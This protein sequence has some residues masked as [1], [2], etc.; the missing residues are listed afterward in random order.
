MSEK[1]TIAADVVT[2]ADTIGKVLAGH[3]PEW[4]SA[5]LADLTARWLAGCHPAMREE[6]FRVHNELVLK[7]TAVNEFLHFGPD[8]HPGWKDLEKPQ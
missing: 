5:V 3:E 8:R 7:L 6:V 1:T 2:T 4:Q